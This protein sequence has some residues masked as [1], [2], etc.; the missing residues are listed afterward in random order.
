MGAQEEK[1]ETQSSFFPV[2]LQAT[3]SDRH[4]LYNACFVTVDC[5]CA[6]DKTPVA[7]NHL[8]SLCHSSQ[9]SPCQTL[10]VCFTL[11]RSAPEN[12]IC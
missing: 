1:G 8:E 4:D 2:L 3:L 5:L 11:H 6:G 10:T 9:S 7:H 12:Q